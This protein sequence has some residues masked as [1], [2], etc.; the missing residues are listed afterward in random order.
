MGGWRTYVAL[1]I[2]LVAFVSSWKPGEPR[3]AVVCSNLAHEP[4]HSPPRNLLPG[5][6]GVQ[7]NIRGE[8]EAMVVAEDT[9]IGQMMAVVDLATTLVIVV[10]DN[11]TPPKVAPGRGKAKDT[12]FERG[13]RV[14]LIVA[15]AGVSSP[16]RTSDE[17]VH[18]VDL[19]ETVIDACRGHHGDTPFP[20]AS[21]SLVPVLRNEAHAPLHDFVFVG[22]QWGMADGDIAVIDQRGLKLRRLDADG[23]R[24]FD[25]E[26]LYDL[27]KDPGETRN[28][29]ADPAYAA[30]IEKLRAELERSLLP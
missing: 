1:T 28:L 4:F 6:Y 20:V 26:E 22:A 15:G 3:L 9:L 19:W 23:D 25:S 5:G 21:V 2:L 17:L 10:G 30:E 14:P 18:I 12:T 16:G 27:A 29:I 24:K 13:V 7:E 8:F 11:G